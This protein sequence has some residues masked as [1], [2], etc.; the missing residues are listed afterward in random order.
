M[1]EPEETNP[2][3]WPTNARHYRPM[4]DNGL[5]L[6]RGFDVFGKNLLSDDTLITVLEVAGKGEGSSESIRGLLLLAHL[7][8]AY[9]ELVEQTWHKEN[10][11]AG[12][13]KLHQAK[14]KDMFCLINKFLV[15]A[16]NTPIRNDANRLQIGKSELTRLF[17]KLEIPYS[18]ALCLTQLHLPY[19]NGSSTAYKGTHTHGKVRASY[20]DTWYILPVR[21]QYK[22]SDRRQNHATSNARNNQMDPLHFL[23]LQD[24]GVDIR[25]SH[26]AILSRHYLEEGGQMTLV[27]NFMDGRWSHAADEPRKRLHEIHEWSTRGDGDLDPNSVKHHPLNAHFIYFTSAMRWWTNALSSVNEQLIAYETLLQNEIDGDIDTQATDTYSLV[28]QALHAI[29]A[30]LQRY[31]SELSSV[32]DTLHALQD[33]EKRCR[34]SCEMNSSSDSTATTHTDFD[35]SSTFGQLT[36]H[37]MQVHTFQHEL[38]DK[39][40]NILA[41]L[42]NRISIAN[43]RM[44]VMNGAKMHAILVATQEDAKISRQ[45]ALQ[46]QELSRAMKRDSVAMKTALL[47]MPFF[48]QSTYLSHASKFWI[49]V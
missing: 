31:N 2:V 20:H 4:L 41:L 28:N 3:I 11:E 15:P 12:L 18:F 47:A 1:A 8:C 43:D 23:H 45:I 13:A 33:Y 36:T 9:L 19:G 14:D 17:A 46:S 21:V 39:L 6:Q 22:C 48:Q 34:D 38:S 29:A 32:R 27:F 42:F 5:H 16:P 24:V 37:L 40:Q 7:I 44:M 30:H 25:S 26:I 49:W 35:T 10:F